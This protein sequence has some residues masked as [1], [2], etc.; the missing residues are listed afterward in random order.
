MGGVA[1]VIVLTFMGTIR[2]FCACCLL[3]ASSSTYEV[4]NEYFWRAGHAAGPW[5]W[6][7]HWR[8]LASKFVCSCAFMHACCHGSRWH[9]FIQMHDATRKGKL[10]M[11]PRS[12]TLL[13]CQCMLPHIS[14]A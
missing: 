14:H 11:L 4:H 1:L 12:L 9:G 3:E 10:N 8:D 7:H 2:A 13:M 6:G 5:S